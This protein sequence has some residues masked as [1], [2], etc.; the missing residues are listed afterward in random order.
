MQ[1]S[2]TVVLPSAIVAPK[3]MCFIRISPVPEE[4]L[5]DGCF[6]GEDPTIFIRGKL[7]YL[8]FELFCLQ[9]SFSAYSPL[10]CS[11]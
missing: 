11:L 6:R 3:N 8:Q 2:E 7:V 1:L 5:L 9:L 4:L 10:R